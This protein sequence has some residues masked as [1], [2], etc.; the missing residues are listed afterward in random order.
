MALTPNTPSKQQERDA[1]AN[2]GFLRE[3]DEALRQDDLLR[4]GQRY[5][6]PLAGL[7]IA[8]LLGLAG[9][10]Y[11]DHT[12]NQAAA[13]LSER[14]ILA[15]DRLGSGG[16][17]ADAAARDLE[18]LMKEGGAGSRA[19]AAM[20]HAAILQEQGKSDLAAKEF[21][22]LAGDS[23]APQPF[24]DLALLRSVSI[25]FDTLPP[26]E[27]ISRLKPL[28]VPGNPWFGSAGELTAIAYLKMGQPDKA[29]PLLAAIG[30]DEKAPRSV[31]G[32]VRQL[33]GQLGYDAGVDMQQIEA[34]GKNAAAAP[35]P[36]PAAAPA[37]KQ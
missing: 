28:A 10:L 22:A 8:G 21:A 30:K 29:G 15:L 17:A 23:T 9:Y 12:R 7:I 32:R 26:A 4:I 20:L 13:E 19:N 37:A 36:A 25:Q 11:W 24:R 27:V 16:V 35:A 18:P 1:A 5:G 3:V 31:R 33:A 34:A 6:K 2:D 14:T